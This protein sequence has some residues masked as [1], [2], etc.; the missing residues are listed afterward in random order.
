MGKALVHPFAV[1]NTWAALLPCLDLESENIVSVN[2]VTGRRRYLSCLSFVLNLTE[3]LG[4]IIILSPLSGHEA[5]SIGPFNP[6]PKVLCQGCD[7]NLRDVN[8]AHH[9]LQE[10][11]IV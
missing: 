5:C 2:Q 7:I 6:N 9:L 3:I 1:Q 10:E 8:M 11:T 4:C